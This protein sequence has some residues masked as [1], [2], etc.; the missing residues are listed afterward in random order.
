MGL[1]GLRFAEGMPQGAPEL[2]KSDLGTAEPMGLTRSGAFYYA[3]YSPVEEYSIRLASF[4]F[5]TGKF[6]SVAKDVPQESF[7]S[8]YN[9]HWSP[10]GKYLAYFS[11]RGRTRAATRVIVIRSADTGQ[12]VRELPIKLDYFQVSCWTPDGR[13]FLADG[14]DFKGRRGIF[15]ID[16]QTG[17][18][19]SV[20]MV[21][22]IGLF[23][24]LSPDGRNLY[25]PGNC[26]KQ[27]VCLHPARPLHRQ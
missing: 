8:I 7:E 24:R 16:A 15:R 6:L 17:E 25:Y 20:F 12:T 1:W 26:R 18:A 21:E 5:T 9:P 13:S 22:G 11:Q 23:P 27:R 19:T 10:D 3:N 14:V 2:I 4:D